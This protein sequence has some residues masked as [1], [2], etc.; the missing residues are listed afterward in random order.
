MTSHP[1]GSLIAMKD[2]GDAVFGVWLVGGGR[3]VEQGELLWE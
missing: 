3:E 2:S 1:S